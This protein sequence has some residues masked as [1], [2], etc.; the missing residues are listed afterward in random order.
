M[1]AL[2]QRLGTAVQRQPATAAPTSKGAGQINPTVAAGPITVRGL[3]AAY[4]GVRSDFLTLI[5]AN[6][7]QPWAAPV[8][9]RSALL[10]RW[11]QRLN[12]AFTLMAIDTIDGQATFLAHAYVESDQFRRLTE[13]ETGRY[14]TDPRKANLDRKGLEALY[15]A[16]SENR[17][18]IDP[19]GRGEWAYIGRGPLQVTDRNEYA[20]TLAY[21]EQQA[22]GRDAAGDATGAATFRSAV[23]AIR[24]DPRQAANP[25]YAFLFSAATMKRAGGDVKAGTV[26]AADKTFEGHGPESSWETGGHTDPQARLK[27]RGYD[28]ALAMLQ[29]GSI[30]GANLPAEIQTV[31]SSHESARPEPEPA[32]A[33]AAEPGP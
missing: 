25:D 23:T 22:I 2:I 5:Q 21:L 8:V 19:G 30:A 9:E 26:A 3:L 11:V 28:Q 14:T 18:R 15:P 20:A 1:V 6:K 7:G 12:E 13:A 27:K 17:S 32:P 10:S 31:L 29:V 33:P 24:A 16:G 4:D